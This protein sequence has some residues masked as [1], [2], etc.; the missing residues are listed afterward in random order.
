MVFTYPTDHPSAPEDA[1]YVDSARPFDLSEAKWMFDQSRSGDVKI[2]YSGEAWWK[3]PEVGKLFDFLG[4][5]GA[6]LIHLVADHDTPH[7]AYLSA[8]LE[9]LYADD[10]LDEWAKA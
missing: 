10:I 4:Y 9:K 2:V 3:L 1:M 5:R 6:N 7:S 8:R